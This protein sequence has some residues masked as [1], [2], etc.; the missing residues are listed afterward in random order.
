MGFINLHFLIVKSQCS[1]KK[2][3]CLLAEKTRGFGQFKSHF[4]MIKSDLLDGEMMW[5]I[6][7]L[8]GWKSPLLGEIPSS[9]SL[10]PCRAGLRRSQHRR[11]QDVGVIGLASAGSRGGKTVEISPQKHGEILVDF[12]WKIPWDLWFMMG[13]F[14]GGF[15]IQWWINMSAK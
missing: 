6:T 11:S 15:M 13:K 10:A 1:S 12:W 2:I 3:S 5:E 8:V 14:Y 9:E 7:I 4:L